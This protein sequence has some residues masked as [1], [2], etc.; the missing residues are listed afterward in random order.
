[1]KLLDGRELAGYITERQAR[2]VR[3]LRQASHVFPKLAI[4]QTTDDPVIDT[5]VRMKQR[6]GHDILIEVDSHHAEGERALALIKELNNDPS[7]HGIIVQ[8]R[9][10]EGL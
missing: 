8:L 10:A 4:I 9:L 7:V 5:Y 2:Q 1:M 6:Y 3:A